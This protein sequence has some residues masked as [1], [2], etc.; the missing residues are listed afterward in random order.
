[1]AY[2]F[3]PLYAIIEPFRM[4]FYKFDPL[5]FVFSASKGGVILILLSLLT[6]WYWKRKKMLS[7]SESK[8]K[9]I[10]EV[11]DLEIV[12]QLQYYLKN[13]LR[14]KF[15]TLVDNPLH[16]ITNNQDAFHVIKKINFEVKEG[17]RIAIV[18]VN[19]AGKTTLCR[20]INGML[21]PKSG[22]LKI[23]GK[24]RGIF[25]TSIGILPELTGRKMLIFLH[26]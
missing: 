5:E 19:G 20:C 17:D 1:M 14:E 7:I 15:I 9:V 2:F 8:R 16:M 4:C 3:N 25:D 18:G 6:C 11:K 12:F 22:S 10:L 23:N 13:S 26:K 21:T 24:I